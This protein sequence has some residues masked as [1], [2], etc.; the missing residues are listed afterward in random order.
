MCLRFCLHTTDTNRTTGMS[1]SPTPTSPAT[2]WNKDGKIL[3]LA[4][5]PIQ[6]VHLGKRQPIWNTWPR[7]LEGPSRSGKHAATTTLIN[8][9]TFGSAQVHYNQLPSTGT[10]DLCRTE[11]K[12]GIPS[13][14]SCC[15]SPQIYQDSSCQFRTSRT[16]SIITWMRSR[17]IVSGSTTTWPV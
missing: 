6:T 8:L 2:K 11:L 9:T 14:Y 17:Q 1:R 5:M 13:P 3:L 15:P 7:N 4:T 10:R 16:Q 12:N